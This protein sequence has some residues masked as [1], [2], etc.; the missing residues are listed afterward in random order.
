MKPAQQ[1]ENW[2]DQQNH[3]KKKVAQATDTALKEG[4]QWAVQKIFVAKHNLKLAK[5]VHSKA[6]AQA[7][8]TDGSESERLLPQAQKRKKSKEEKYQAKLHK[9]VAKFQIADDPE[10]AQKYQR[11]M[12]KLRRKLRNIDRLRQLA[13]AKLAAI[14]LKATNMHRDFKS[15]H[16]PMMSE[17]QSLNEDMQA[18]ITKLN[19]GKAEKDEKVTRAKILGEQKAAL[20]LKVKQDEQN[21]AEKERATK[22]YEAQLSKTTAEE[23]LMAGE[24]TSA[25]SK[26]ASAEATLKQDTQDA[27]NAKL[28]SET[29]RRHM[30]ELQRQ[31]EEAILANQTHHVLAMQDAMAESRKH[32]QSANVVTN[33]AV[34]AAE[35]A[36]EAV[37]SA[38]RLALVNDDMD[39]QKYEIAL[40]HAKKAITLQRHNETLAEQEVRAAKNNVSAQLTKF[41]MLSAQADRNTTAIAEAQAS[42]RID[43]STLR[44]KKNR[45]FTEQVK[46]NN[47]VNSEME[48][49]QM[50][51]EQA[52]TKNM[53]QQVS[54]EKLDSHRLQTEIRD[55]K[56][57]EAIAED[58]EKKDRAALKTEAAAIDK[59]TKREEE[60]GPTL[61]LV[62]QDNA[63]EAA[64]QKRTEQTKAKITQVKYTA[65]ME[66]AK[67]RN[68]EVQVKALTTQAR[69]NAEESVKID[70]SK[71]SIAPLM[72]QEGTIQAQELVAT[73]PEEKILFRTQAKG[74][75]DK[76]AKLT[77]EQDAAQDKNLKENS[78]LQSFW[79]ESHDNLRSVEVARQSL[80]LQAG[81]SLSL[82][83]YAQ[84][85]SEV[86]QIATSAD[87]VKHELTQAQI[88]MNNPPALE[89]NSQGLVTKALAATSDNPDNASESTDQLLANT[90][91]DLISVEATA[92]VPAVAPKDDY[93]TAHIEL[94][95]Q[96][97]QG[98]V[99]AKASEKEKALQTSELG[100]EEQASKNIVNEAAAKASLDDL[101][102]QLEIS[103][104]AVASANQNA[105]SLQA[106]LLHADEAEKKQV[107]AYCCVVL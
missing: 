71:R 66:L 70:K 39:A 62:G 85:R 96:K 26:M 102:S 55:T 76:I 43:Q 19:A 92:D 49:K 15:V 95:A 60:K 50:I 67:L 54:V 32:L 78:R 99:D 77:Q 65:D 12:A 57:E 31:I 30:Q 80:E 91:K 75:S 33:S 94:A 72:K 7:E 73:I 64:E 93:G 47:T 56:E 3:L 88:F 63:L 89:D 74:I 20:E 68:M 103:T 42:F 84:A 2:D 17:L 59:E 40:E 9:L 82:A 45:L 37:K 106:K 36:K 13:R 35:T 97:V 52:A 24:Q 83:Q 5:E 100:Q 4:S 41:Q 58:S 101:T 53:N 22:A 51:A 87:H 1:A 98:L 48:D 69:L 18:K 105:E 16:K 79:G 90:Q 25:T 21:K 28:V 11:K 29:T 46:V 34:A 23:A 107:P 14:K 8:E 6:A 81:A 38:E 104:H 86:A 27:N 61:K 44:A 10:T